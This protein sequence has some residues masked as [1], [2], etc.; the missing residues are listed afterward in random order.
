MSLISKFKSIQNNKSVNDILKEVG[1][2][3]EAKKVEI[4]YQDPS[5]DK[6][7]SDRY[8]GITNEDQLLAV[9]K[10]SYGVIQYSDA[11]A[12]LND[13]ISAGSTKVKYGAITD[14]GA[15]L[16][17][18]CTTDYVAQ[19]DAG[20]SVKCYFTV[21]TSHDGTAS[22]LISCTPI[23]DASQTV[24]TPMGAGI[25]K[26][27]HSKHVKDRMANTS[28][29]MNKIS[30]YFQEFTETIDRLKGINVTKDQENF[31]LLLL[32][33]GESQRAVN[34]RE[35]ISDIFNVGVVSKIPSCKGTLFGLLISAQFYADNYKVVRKSHIRNE[36]DA[37]IESKLS[38]DA[39]RMKAEAFSVALRLE[40][41]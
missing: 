28:R 23:H 40:K 14:R 12:F 10:S 22:L 1:G 24:F 6:I 36:I 19:L 11:V 15:R 3:F 5:K 25:L 21:S 4:Y 41:M 13:L 30:H 37:Y 33:D 8:C 32:E 34:I 27:R 26:M 35:K 2:D 39:A 17:L 9:V 7:L 38:G 16:H 31:F 29:A 20:D 18:M